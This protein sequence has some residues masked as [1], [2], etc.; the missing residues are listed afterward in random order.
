MPLGTVEQVL[1]AIQVMAFGWLLLGARRLPSVTHKTTGGL[2]EMVYD[3][4]LTENVA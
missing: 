2:S 4:G 3:W 1:Q